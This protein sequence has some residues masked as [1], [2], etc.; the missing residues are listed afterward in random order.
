MQEAFIY[1]LGDS[2]CYLIVGV[3]L[4]KRFGA[5]LS[6][7]ASCFVVL[8]K[9]F[10]YI[11]TLNHIKRARVPDIVILDTFREFKNILHAETSISLSGKITETV[12]VA[13]RYIS[14]SLILRTI[15]KHRQPLLYKI[16]QIKKQHMKKKT[17]LMM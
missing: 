11:F 17:K 14:G 7:L 16:N 2:I 10:P 6:F 9:F 1:Q 4:Y 5:E 3:Y 8:L 12:T 15:S 13:E